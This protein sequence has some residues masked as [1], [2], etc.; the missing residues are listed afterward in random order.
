M[1]NDLTVFEK[2]KSV[3]ASGGFASTLRCNVMIFI[4]N[5]GAPQIGVSHRPALFLP[6]SRP[7]FDTPHYPY[8]S[9][10]LWRLDMMQLRKALLL[11]SVLGFGLAGANAANADWR[12]D[13][14]GYGDDHGGP[15]GYY[16][17]YHHWHF[18]PG[19]YGPPPVYYAPPAYYP[20]PPVYYAPPPPVYYAPPPPVYYAPPPPVYYGPPVITFGF[21]P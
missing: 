2:A 12:H 10:E 6:C 3:T 20:P 16:D 18:Y 14:G 7:G 13:G 8:L 19:Y 11:A 21:R 4:N 1:A 5:R 17:P 15:R 9:R